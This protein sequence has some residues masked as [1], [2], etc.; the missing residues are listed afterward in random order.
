M[1]DTIE[2]YATIHELP[3]SYAGEDVLRCIMDRLQLDKSREVEVDEIISDPESTIGKAFDLL[4]SHK[5][6][7][8]VVALEVPKK[9]HVALVESFINKLR[10]RLRATCANFQVQFGVRMPLQ[11]IIKLLPI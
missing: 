3:L 9:T 1:I 2:E 4:K 11:F 6:F 8:H 10:I 7:S 5:V